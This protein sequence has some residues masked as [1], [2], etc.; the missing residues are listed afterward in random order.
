[1]AGATV[2]TDPNELFHIRCWRMEVDQFSF[3]I[4]YSISL[5]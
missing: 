1:L 3:L 5:L 2:E 4:G